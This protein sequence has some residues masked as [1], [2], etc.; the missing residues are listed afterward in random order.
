MRIDFKNLGLLPYQIQYIQDDS[1]IKI[2]EKS[3]QVG[4]TRTQALEDVIDA[5]IK[6]KSDV[7]FSSNSDTNAR[8][9]IRYCKSFANG[10]H[11]VVKDLTDIDVVG[12]TTVYC[13]EFK[14]GFRITA[15]SSNPEQ[16]H[17]KNGKIIL[18]E[19]AR[20]DS[21]FDVWEAAAPAALIWGRP[22]RIISTHN[23]KKSMFNDFI[24]K[25]L[26]GKLNGN[27]K[28]FK[29]TIEDAVEQGLADKV[30]GRS[31]SYE[32][33]RSWIDEL[34]KSVANSTIWA[35][36]YM[37]EPQDESESF[38]SSML[39][40]A[41]A[42][43]ELLPLDQL[44]TCKSLYGG[45]DIGRYKNLSILWINEQVSTQRAITRY[46]RIM[47]KENFPR[48]EEIVTKII[49][50]C[51]NLRRL[52]IDRTGMGVGLTDYLQRTFGNSRIEGVNF[53]Q[54]VKE[55]L[56][57]RLKKYLEDN[58]FDI[59][60]SEMIKDD[61]RSVRQQT[62]LSG[63]IR[64]L[65][66]TDQETGSHADYFWAAALALEAGT[67]TYVTADVRTATRKMIDSG[68]KLLKGF[69]KEI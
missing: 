1:Q 37:C 12:D 43:A 48:Q 28:H 3:R 10:F 55:E 34:R 4:M 2:Y 56:G 58:N 50:K 13:I 20:R 59:P 31:L 18:D 42:K 62:T 25:Y 30:L 69:S 53:T 66:D 36:Q 64:L 17:G 52:C 65:A 67:G 6:G 40:E 8:E 7:W 14:N 9:Y 32:E 5:G 61:F 16:L 39:C 45:L 24:Q 15:V 27:W 23:G 29:T 47:D 63:N 57:F 46:I 51:P 26:A 21:E 22:L 33:R 35:Q 41:N 49:R 60:D 44:A 54:K 19:F 68:R 11:C 38:I